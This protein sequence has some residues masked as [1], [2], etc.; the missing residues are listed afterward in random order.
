MPFC[1]NSQKSKLEFIHLLRLKLAS[2]KL[3]AARG[4][5]LDVIAGEH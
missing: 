3:A 2:A 1:T 5:S 4:V